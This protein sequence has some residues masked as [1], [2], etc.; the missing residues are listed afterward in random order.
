[1]GSRYEAK[2]FPRYIRRRVSRKII[3]LSKMIVGLSIVNL[4][5]RA[6]EEGGSIESPRK[7]I[8]LCHLSSMKIY[9]DRLLRI[10]RTFEK[11]FVPL[12]V[13]D[14]RRYVSFLRAR[15]RRRIINI[16]GCLLSL[17]RARLGS[18]ARS[19]K[20]WYITLLLN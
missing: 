7:V 5:S 15:R 16:E 13:T 20:R 10:T 11:E 2:E 1:M 12:K 6:K 19:R 17:T 3:V 14:R 4:P 9:R 18:N 8:I